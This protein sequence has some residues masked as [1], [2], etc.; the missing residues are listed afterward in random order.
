MNITEASRKIAWLESRLDQAE[1]ELV[2][3]NQLLVD[4]GFP[5][6][7][8]TLKQTITDLMDEVNQPRYNPPEDYPPTQTFNYFE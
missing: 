1:S 8:N 5:E 7:I 2:H 3:L 6:G 4:C